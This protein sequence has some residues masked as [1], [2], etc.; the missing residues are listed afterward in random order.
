MSPQSDGTVQSREQHLKVALV[1]EQFDPKAGGLEHWTFNLAKELL[2]RGHEV[3]IVAARFASADLPIMQHQFLADPS[4]QTQ[5]QHIEAA[6]QGIRVD[7]VHD[8]G[9]G[10]SADVFQPHT[11]S[12]VLNLRRD[13]ASMPIALR[14]RKLLSPR[15]W[16]WRRQLRATEHRQMSSALCVIA[17]SELVKDLLTTM[18]GFT[19]ARIAVVPNGVDTLRFSPAQR[20]A[21]RDAGRRAL[22]LGNEVAFLCVAHNFRLKGVDTALQA[23]ASLAPRHPG[24]R[25]VVAGDGAIDEY[26]RKATQLGVNDRVS[27]LGKVDEIRPV[28]AAADVLIHATHHDACSLATLEALAAGVPVITTRVNGAAGR[29]DGTDAGLVIDRAG[30]SGAL[31]LAMELTLDPN[32]RQ[33]MG[34]AARAL[35]PRLSFEENVAGVAEIYR[36]VLQSRR[37]DAARSLPLSN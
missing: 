2:A 21:D 24:V 11:G 12:R 34:E 28:Y 13:L 20:G 27:F 9:H 4:P 7:I 36:A 16:N 29:F 5:A 6:L 15:F 26:R 33:R 22:G 17:V 23:I 19:A 37:V 14:M 3:H 35:A 8:M 18:Y 25:L 30:D 1:L 31:A 32:R 10:W